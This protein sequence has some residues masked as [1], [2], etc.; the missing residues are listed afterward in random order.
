MCFFVFHFS[1]DLD[2]PPV[3][4][5]EFSEKIAL[6]RLDEGLEDE[7]DVSSS[8]GRGGTCVDTCMY[9]HVICTYACTCQ[10]K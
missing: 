3:K 8:L 10:V 7:Y 4:V 5:G 2:H 1:A 6:L 9:V